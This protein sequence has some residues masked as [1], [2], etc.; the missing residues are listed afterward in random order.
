MKSLMKPFRL[1]LVLLATGMS[2]RAQAPPSD[3]PRTV[4]AVYDREVSAK[5]SMLLSVA[6]AMP[7]DK[8]DF[9][10]VNGE[11]KGVRTFGQ[12]IRHVAID[13]YVDGAALLQDKVPIDPGVHENGPDSIRTKAE[14][15]KLL[16][17]SYVYLRRAMR[18]VNQKNLMQLINFQNANIPRLMIVNSAISHP[19]DHYGQLIEYL[20][21]NGID[22]QAKP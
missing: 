15:V 19:M 18:T 16:R 10:P 6:E 7:E 20:R 21:M 9:A 11:F 17:D 14:L 13:N 5:E 4:T 22:P 2:A 1:S 12:M 8:Y 3:L